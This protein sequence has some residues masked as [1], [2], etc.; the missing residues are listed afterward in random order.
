MARD[1][2]GGVA[3]LGRHPLFLVAV[4]LYGL[5]LAGTRVWGWVPPFWVSGWLADVLCMPVVLTLALAV[6]RAVRRR[7]GL[8]LPKCW[9]LG[10]WVYVSAWFEGLAPLWW[11]GRYTADWRDVLAYALGTL[12]FARWINRSG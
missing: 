5:Y 9:L 7:P 10:A 1:G 3:A 4:G 2:G 6:Q 11:P 8:V 12:A